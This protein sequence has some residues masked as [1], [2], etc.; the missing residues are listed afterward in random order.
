M[1]ATIANY[2]LVP[3]GAYPGHYGMCTNVHYIGTPTY[4]KRV[5]RFLQVGNPNLSLLWAQVAMSGINAKF[6]ACC[7]ACE[8]NYRLQIQFRLR[9]L[10]GFRLSNGEGMERMWSYLRRF[11]RMTKEMRPSHRIDVL[12]DALVYYA[13]K[14]ISSI[15]WFGVDIYIIIIIII[16]LWY[17]T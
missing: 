15:G 4:K 1:Q 17:Y 3:M 8:C 12:T 6:F 16:L 5:Q 9:N 13:Q 2:V 11:S 7:L 10:E 14:S